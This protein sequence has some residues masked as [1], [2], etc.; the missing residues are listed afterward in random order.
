MM[1]LQSRVMT[2]L[3][4]GTLAPKL[5]GEQESLPRSTWDVAGSLRHQVELQERSIDE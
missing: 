4:L 2:H 1:H 3:G 5:Q